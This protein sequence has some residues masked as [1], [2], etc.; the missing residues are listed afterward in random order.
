LGY[1]KG[2]WSAGDLLP[3]TRLEPTVRPIRNKQARESLVIVQKGAV[4]RRIARFRDRA[5]PELCDRRGAPVN[6]KADRPLLRR[7]A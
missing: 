2:W 3:A 5:S 1:K 7:C 4:L 6:Y